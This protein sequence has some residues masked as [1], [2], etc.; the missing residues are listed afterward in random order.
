M[1]YSPLRSVDC[2]KHSPLIPSTYL[3]PPRRS[4]IPIF[5]ALASIVLHAL[6]LTPV[7]LGASTHKRSVTDSQKL[8]ASA[9]SSEESALTLVLIEEPDTGAERAPKS[10][11]LAS[12]LPDP[13]ALLAPVAMPDLPMAAAD[14]LDD[15]MEESGTVDPNANSDP[16]QAMMFGRYVGQIDA[17]IERAW[18]RPRTS[19][20]AG[21]F[22]CRVKIVQERS[23]VVEEIE[24]VRCNGDIPWQ[25]SLV[26]AIQS[27]SPL[28]A[29]PDPSVFSA[30]LTLEFSS[31]PFS[32]EE[33]SDGFERE[34]QT[35]MK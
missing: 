22:V 32:R 6:L 29:P 30:V 35:A 3:P 19:I 28:P 8:A 15:R 9:S 14:Q 24:I 26:H 18:I 1:S 16:G 17:R 34:T 33:D 20:A 21:L 12:L 7:M 11:S 23:G 25:T 10:D 27:A 5:G 31:R 2:M 4:A 13:G